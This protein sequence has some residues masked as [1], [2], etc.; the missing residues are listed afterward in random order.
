MYRTYRT[1]DALKQGTRRL[2]LKPKQ[3]HTLVDLYISE[4]VDGLAD[5]TW[6]DKDA[7]SL[8][9]LVK[10]LLLLPEVPREIAS[11]TP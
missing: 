11:E 5:A 7:R 1:R 4:L 6:T 3:Q 10:A 9:T 8:A 2:L